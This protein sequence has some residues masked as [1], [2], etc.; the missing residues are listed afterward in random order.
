MDYK[1]L[2]NFNKYGNININFENNKIILKGPLGFIEKEYK[3][4]NLKILSSNIILIKKNFY[5]TFLK[6]LEKLIIGISYGWYFD[7]AI[8]GRGFNF[9]LFSKNNKKYLKIKIGYSHFVYYEL[10][11]TIFIIVS[12]KKNR[13]ILFSL[14]F[15][16]LSKIA[17]QIRK[18]RSKHTY[19]IQGIKY[20]DENIIIK[21][22]KQKQV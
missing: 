14:N 12:K 8:F 19:K 7:L 13:L 2:T 15:F 18:I 6:E 17:L 21:P 22:G 5:F 10:P 20:F 4:K 16:E 11:K 3:L 1:L 9:R